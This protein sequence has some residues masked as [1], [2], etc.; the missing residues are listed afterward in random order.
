[1]SQR[2]TKTP[3]EKAKN[4]TAHQ[5]VTKEGFRDM[6][7]AISYQPVENAEELRTK[8][9]QLIVGSKYCLLD[10]HTFV[11]TDDWTQ[12]DEDRTLEIQQMLREAMGPDS[13]IMY[14]EYSKGHH[15]GPCF[16]CIEGTD[17]EIFVGFY[18]DGQKIRV[19]RMSVESVTSSG[20][21]LGATWYTGKIDCHDVELF[22]ILKY[23]GTIIDEISAKWGLDVLIHSL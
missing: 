11:E 17:H 6:V 4:T 9:Y 22:D 20:F 7:R 21:G 2:K 23:R 15:S 14:L 3:K 12:K 16:C 18:S 5:D 13:I 1:M 10:D 19:R 8:Y